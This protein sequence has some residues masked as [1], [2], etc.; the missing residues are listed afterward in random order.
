MP[1]SLPDH[2]MSLLVQ[3]E[4]GQIWSGVGP[5]F[6]VT[7]YPLSYGAY[8]QDGTPI[9]FFSILFF[10]FFSILL[11]VF[12]LHFSHLLAPLHLAVTGRNKDGRYQ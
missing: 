11:L 3:A 4:D 8:L 12:Y 2:R 5:G 1:V 6:P 10:E 9:G 7:L